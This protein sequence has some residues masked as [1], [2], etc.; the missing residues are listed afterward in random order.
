MKKSL[1]I[2]CIVGVLVGCARDAGGPAPVETGLRPD[3]SA[4]F[5]RLFLSEEPLRYQD[6]IQFLSSVQDASLH[7]KERAV[8]G[9]KL[10]QF[11]SSGSQDRPYAPDTQVTGVASPLAFLRLK[12]IEMLSEIGTAEDADFILSLDTQSREEHP[13]FDEECQKAVE[14]LRARSREHSY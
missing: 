9:A 13:V 11:L 10:K 1:F 12:A 14:K 8:V 7:Q 2:V 5:D 6:N 4:E 3:F